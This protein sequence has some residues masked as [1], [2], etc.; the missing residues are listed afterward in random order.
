M[1]HAVCTRDPHSGH[2]LVVVLE[3]KQVQVE[4][5]AEQPK[6]F[7]VL[8]LLEMSVR[9]VR[10]RLDVELRLAL[11]RICQRLAHLTDE[12]LI[13][14]LAVGVLE[15]IIRAMLDGLDQ[16]FDVQPTSTPTTSAASQQLAMGVEAYPARRLCLACA[17]G[18]FV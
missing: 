12:A 4:D 15:R 7:G 10:L 5:L 16:A 2:T 11:A 8:P 13:A 6:C 17:L 18:P 3:K 1:G 14:L 9:K